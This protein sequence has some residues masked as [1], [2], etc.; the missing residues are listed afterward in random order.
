MKIKKQYQE[1]FDILNENKN[2][3]VSTILPQLTEL[4]QAANSNGSETGRTFAKDED[5]NV[6]AVYCYYHKKWEP[7]AHYAYGTKKSTASGLNT[8]CKE[9]VSQWTKQQREF[10]KREGEILDHLE[11]QTMDIGEIQRARTEAQQA[12]VEVH[13]SKNEAPC[14]DTLEELDAWMNEG[15]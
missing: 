1:I 14:F 3:K 12:K 15:N 11:A 8:M 7:V 4:M 6:Y 10:K 9:G 2:R 5:G 13:G